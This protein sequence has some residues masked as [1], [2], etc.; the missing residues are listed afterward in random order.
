MIE[1]RYDNVSINELAIV[2]VKIT[3]LLG[4]APTG[5]SDS[6]NTTIVMFASA[7]TDPQKSSLNSFM[8]G[9]NLDVI[10]ASTNTRYT[11]ADIEAV[12]QATGL[13]LDIYPTPN[14]L[15]IQFQKVLTTSEKNSFKGAV[16]NLLTVT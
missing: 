9:T 5:L 3:R 7:L 14:G 12:K 1:Y 13:D 10:P 4:I 16:A 2:A 8:A 15:V 6:G 11:L